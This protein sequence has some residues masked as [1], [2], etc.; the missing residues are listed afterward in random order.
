MTRIVIVSKAFYFYFSL[1]VC[2]HNP[3]HNPSHNPTTT[4]VVLARLGCWWTFDTSLLVCWIIIYYVISIFFFLFLVLGRRHLRR[5]GARGRRV[6]AG[7]AARAPIQSII[8]IIHNPT[9]IPIIL[10]RIHTIL[11]QSYWFRG[12]VGKAWIPCLRLWDFPSNPCDF[13]IAPPSLQGHHWHCLRTDFCGKC[14][15]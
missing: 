7:A 3:C 11:L 12:L 5:A 15:R 2:S 14:S 1:S 9:T 4:R 6:G 13:R 10:S 8:S